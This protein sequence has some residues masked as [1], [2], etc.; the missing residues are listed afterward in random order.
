MDH[1]KLPTLSVECKTFK[2]YLLLDLDTDFFGSGIYDIYN[3]AM[4]TSKHAFFKIESNLRSLLNTQFVTVILRINLAETFT[5][6]CLL[7]VSLQRLS[8]HASNRK[9]CNSRCRHVANYMVYLFFLTDN[10]GTD[11]LVNYCYTF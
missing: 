4:R 11:D 10:R 3:K 5:F 8:S 6:S 9:V 2:I 7:C 1:E